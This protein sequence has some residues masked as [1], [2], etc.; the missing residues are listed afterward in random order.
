M[1]GTLHDTSSSQGGHHELPMLHHPISLL[2]ISQVSSRTGSE[3][4]QE[5]RA[6]FDGPILP[7]YSFGIQLLLD[8]D[9][10]VL[11]TM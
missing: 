2:S 6:S 8:F 9:K 3:G 10:I 5:D 1:L 11:I 7:L 4:A